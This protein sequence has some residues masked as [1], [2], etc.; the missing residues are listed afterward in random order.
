M[1]SSATALPSAD[2]T[3]FSP[4]TTR[5][6]GEPLRIA[7]VG[8][9]KMALNHIKA[10]QRTTS[11]AQVVAIAD[12][13]A[14]ARAAAVALAPGATGHD[15]LGALLAAA[16]PD[17]VHIVTPP[18]THRA[19]ALEALRAGAHVY[20]EKPFAESVAETEDVLLEAQRQGRLVCAGHQLLFEAPTRILDEYLPAV[21]RVVHVESYFSFRPVRR[22][23]GGRAPQRTDL[24]LLDILPHP[25]YLLLHFL[26]QCA[27]EGTT[28]ITAL[29]VSD[30]G[31]VHALVRRGHVTGT[32]I[33]TLEGRP[34]ES[35][36]RVVG[37]NGALFADYVRGTV[38]RQLGP[39]TAGIDKVIAPYRA[40]W[41]MATG[42]TSAL[43]RRVLKKQKSYPGLAELFDAFY[44]ATRQAAPAPLSTNSILETTRLW[45]QVEQRIAALR[46]ASM[47]P[48]ANADRPPVVV[49][50]GTGFLGKE[51]VRTL[52]ERGEHV[53]VLAR[54]EPASWERVPGADYRVADLGRPLP[55]ELLAGARAVIHAAAETAGGW[56]DHQR[57]SLDATENI[58]R[59]AAAAG[60][61]TLVHVSSLAVLADARVIKDDGQL[62]AESKSRGPYVW[63]KLE[64]ERMARD[65]GRELGVDVKVARPGPIVDARAFEPPGRLGKRVGNIFVAVGS[66]GDA[67]G[68]VDVRFAAR[69][70]AWM[71]AKPTEAPEVLNLLDPVSAPKRELLQQLRRGNP[72]ISV[73]W[74]P[75]LVL[76][77]LSW[78][79]IVL[80][81]VL[82]PKKPAIN[83]AKVFAAQRFDTS[84]IAALQGKIDAVVK[85]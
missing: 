12:P 20:V 64:S 25:V 65:I 23:P 19:L 17:V 61:K 71:V 45:E 29:E 32:L 51:T 76:H 54:R 36:V 24:Q 1:S 37:T 79:A 2:R 33:V 68:V 14:E 35:Y 28:E 69:T 85:G 63:G 34:V 3:S 58:V 13:S 22:A 59:A 56:E 66:S 83:V 67:L 47:P 4:V 72:D 74:L 46:L 9:G 40:A 82:R 53:R 43:T 6:P 80:Q 7:V 26:E 57:N 39:G 15:T 84:R 18:A 11:G 5:A 44:L 41:Q 60:V 50:G 70:L 42:T 62:I 31:T 21:Q 38:Q 75:S 30:S 73:V 10:I 8:A 27:A 49:T 77:P 78:A 81:K 52:L 16:R 55:A 48:V